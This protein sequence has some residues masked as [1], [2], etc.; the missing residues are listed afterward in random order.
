MTNLEA[1]RL[2]E[3]KDW[4]GYGPGGAVHYQ[5]IIE[6]EY[7]DLSIEMLCQVF[8]DQR[9]DWQGII[10]EYEILDKGE[11]DAAADE[12]KAERERDQKKLAAWTTAAQ[13]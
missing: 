3:D 2:L 9:G 10:R 1:V 4:I 11:S 5:S 12:M 7:P 6:K 8:D 13:R